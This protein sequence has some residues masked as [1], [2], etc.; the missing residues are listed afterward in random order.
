MPLGAAE[1]HSSIKSELLLLFLVGFLFLP[2]SFTKPFNFARRFLINF[3]VPYLVSICSMAGCLDLP[4]CT[5]P[6]DGIVNFAADPDIVYLYTRTLN[7]I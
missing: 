6:N 5:I 7:E 1:R 4:N 3:P 2:T